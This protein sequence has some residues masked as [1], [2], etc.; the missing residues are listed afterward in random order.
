MTERNLRIIN[1]LGLTI[2]LI[3]I[4]VVGIISEDNC[5]MEIPIGLIGFGLAV[6][7]LLKCSKLY[8]KVL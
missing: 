4:P 8:G 6:W 7:S 5:L 3:G 2:M 1:I